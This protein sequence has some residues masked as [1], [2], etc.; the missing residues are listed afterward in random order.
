MI[1]VSKKTNKT[2][3]ILF[4]TQ[5]LFVFGRSKAGKQNLEIQNQFLIFVSL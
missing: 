2:P 3:E 1:F 4:Y 5:L